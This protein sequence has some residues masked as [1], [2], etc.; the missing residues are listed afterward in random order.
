MKVLL[1]ALAALGAQG[2]LLGNYT[3]D[4]P[5][6]LQLA[7]PPKE[8]ERYK[9]I[10][11]SEAL[12]KCTSDWCGSYRMDWIKKFGACHSYGCGH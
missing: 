12:Q 2:L 4:A 5:A 7:C 3:Q 8:Y 1:L 11:C 6:S 9:T 10:L